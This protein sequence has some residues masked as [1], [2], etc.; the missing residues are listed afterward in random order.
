M[1]MASFER[2]RE[3]GATR[4]GRPSWGCSR[5]R[6]WPRQSIPVQAHRQRMNPSGAHHFDQDVRIQQHPLSRCL[7]PGRAVR[8]A[9][10]R[11]SSAPSERRERMPRPGRIRRSGPDFGDV[12][13]LTQHTGGVEGT[14]WHLPRR[15][16]LS[17]VRT[18][19]LRARSQLS[20]RRRSSSARIP[21]TTLPLPAHGSQRSGASRRC[22]QAERRRAAGAFMAFLR[23]RCGAAAG[24]A[25]VC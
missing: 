17:Q 21:G 1:T 10:R 8:T 25:S 19:S 12:T 7:E 3:P 13:G 16:H 22:P 5:P 6:R 18:G 11:R 20:C 14:L 4:D 2:A 15:L 24:Q 9:T 23:C